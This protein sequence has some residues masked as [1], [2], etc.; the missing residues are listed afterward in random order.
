[1][2]YVCPGRNALGRAN[3][4][5]LAEIGVDLVELRLNPTVER[6]FIRKA[7]ERTG[8]SGLVTHMAIYRWP[9]RIALAHEIPLVVYGE[10]SAFEYGSEDPSLAGSRVDPA[11]LKTFGVTAGT[12]A[13]DWIGED[14]SARDLAPLLT[15]PPELVAA[16]D[17]HVLFLGHYFPWD[18]QT[19]L[20]V[21]EAHGFRAR[22]A[23]AR[24]G[25][26][27]FVNI[28]D[29]MIGVH[30]HPKWHKFGITRSWDTLSMEIRSG[31]MSRAQAV[32]EIARR[33]DE[34]PTDDIRAFCDYLDMP[35]ADYYSVLE[36]FRDR[37]LWSRSDDRWKIEGFLIDDFAWPP[38]R[39]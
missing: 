20:R 2:S 25:H 1:V 32:H 29:D 30:H 27:D 31:R 39:P 12:T 8:I 5:S 22:A 15:P 3:L 26:Y 36:R 9:V 6:V 28:D 23:G 19:S 14:L 16:R 38:D 35:T 24:V 11:W 10:N 18:P 37:E 21:A 13:E 34:P 17:L 7:F 4:A 33:G